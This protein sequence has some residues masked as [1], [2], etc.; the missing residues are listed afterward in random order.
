MG[1]IWTLDTLPKLKESVAGKR[2]LLRVDLNV[3]MREGKISDITRIER[4]LP[5]VRELTYLG[6][7]IILMSHF[8]RPNGKVIT[9][10]SIKPLLEI[11]EAKMDGQ[12]ILFLDDLF[13]P[14]TQ[15]LVNGLP[16]GGVALLENLRFHAGEE[17]NDRKF[18]EALAALGDIFV[19]DAFQPLIV[20]TRLLRASHMFYLRPQVGRW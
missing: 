14:R 17:A 5:T 6:C 12:Q 11:L 9:G 2:V 20:L 15:V 7:K 10:M 4:F 16:A 3:P 18:V 13:N 1:K 8:G 19:N